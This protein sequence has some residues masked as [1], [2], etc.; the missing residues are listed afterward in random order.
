M[1]Y[2]E[3]AIQALID[4][5]GWNQSTVD[6]LNLTI[7]DENLE[8]TSTRQ[9]K[10]FHSTS[11]VENVY[12]CLENDLT[13]NSEL[14]AELLKMKREVVIEVLAKIFD[15]NVLA[16]YAEIQGVKSLNYA[17]EYSGVIQAKQSVFDESIGWCMAS[18]CLRM[19]LTTNRSNS[20]ETNLGMNYDLMKYELDGI[21]NEY[22]RSIGKGTLDNYEAAVTNAINVLFPTYKDPNIIPGDGNNLSAPTLRGRSDLW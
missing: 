17:I 15:T 18:K 1:L 11:I 9:Y 19:F 16:N 2:N 3:T 13:D 10:S 4:R 12:Y 6:S 20:T 21:K 5:I 14:N 7:S 22:G 8:S